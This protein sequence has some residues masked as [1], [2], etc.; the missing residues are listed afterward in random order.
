[1][2]HVSSEQHKVVMTILRRGQTKNAKESLTS[3]CTILCYLHNPLLDPAVKERLK[4]KFDIRYLLAK[5]SLPFTKYPTIHELRE[6]HRIELGFSYKKRESAHNFAH[7]IAESQRQ[8]FHQ[9]LS[10]T[11]FSVF[12]GWVN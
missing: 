8:E 7:Y 10:G 9:M 4:K 3:Y 5:E 1:M 6:Q 2:D 12:N 11:K